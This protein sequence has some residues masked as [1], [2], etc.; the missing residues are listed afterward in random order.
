MFTADQ[1][2]TR[3]VS[4]ATSARSQMAGFHAVLAKPFDV[5]ELVDTVARAIGY[6]VPFDPSHPPSCSAPRC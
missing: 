2:A 6:G 1:Q 3:E 4:Q 5:D